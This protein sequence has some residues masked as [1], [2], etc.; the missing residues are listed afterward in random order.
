MTFPPDY[1]AARDRF[2]AAAAKLGWPVQSLPI[3]APGPRGEELTID[4]AV[5]TPAGREPVL[6]L[7][8][9][10]HG[11]EGFFGSAVQLAVMEEWARSGPPAGVR[12]VFLHAVCPF[13]YA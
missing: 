2:R 11:V 3:T 13:G 5:S 1:F 7:S 9:G 4:A 10:V 8:S 12:S 6:V